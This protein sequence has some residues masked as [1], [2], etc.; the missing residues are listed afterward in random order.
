MKKLKI[1]FIVHDY[2]RHG[3]HARYVAELVSRFKK[4]HEV[5]VYTS[6][7]E[8]PNPEK[9]HFHF[10]PS[11]RLTALTTILSFI[12]F[13]FFRS[14]SGFD[15]VHSQGLCG[16]R[17][18]FVTAHICN[19]AW[20][21]MS[22]LNGVK[23]STKKKINKYIVTW[24]ESFFYKTLSWTRIIAVSEKIKQDLISYYGV[25]EKK[26]GVIYHGV[27]IERFSPN[28]AGKIRS[29][30][31]NK[32]KI[33]ENEVIFLCVGDWQK[34][35]FALAKSLKLLESGK[36]LIVSKTPK[37][38]IMADLKENNVT[39]R[40]VYV[41]PTNSVENYYYASDVFVFPSYYDAFGLVVTEAMACGLPVITSFS[42]G[43]S[44]LIQ[45]SY[46]GLL[47]DSSWDIAQ[48]ASAMNILSQNPNLRQKIGS[49]GRDIIQEYN[50]DECAKKTMDYYQEFLTKNRDKR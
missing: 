44:E 1:A 43:A 16:F 24:L 35:G 34:V 46:S 31:R 40:V 38:M 19:K 2:H 36:L 25:N 13:A 30:I 48:L 5:H 42:V 28:N 26:I 21:T 32:L 4:D 29:E 12:P 50:W 33:G 49:K 7:W 23:L 11:F 37:D 20:Y 22:E 47:I 27:D 41:G 8:E 6:I 14:F 45:N 15:I 39:N 3:G 10:V 17:Q 9:I 18:N